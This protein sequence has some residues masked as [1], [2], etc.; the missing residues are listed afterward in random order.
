MLLSCHDLDCMAIKRTFQCRRLGHALASCTVGM[1]LQ[2][3][4]NS[5]L[6][7]NL[8]MLHFSC[9]MDVDACDDTIAGLSFPLYR[10]AV[11]SVTYVVEFCARTA[12]RLSVI[13]DASSRT[14][15]W[16]CI[17]R[18]RQ[19]CQ[20]STCPFVLEGDF[21]QELIPLGKSEAVETPR[22]DRNGIWKAYHQSC[23]GIPAL[24]SSALRNEL[25]GPVG[26]RASPFAMQ[27]R[28]KG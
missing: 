1:N 13:Q 4:S 26:I 28:G 11:C 7:S 19:R 2:A 27:R 16:V 3:P 12:P 22:A 17:S 20:R 8:C 6:S 5:L 24:T 21:S 23:R 9:T 10:L 14:A 25:Y 18:Y 15:L